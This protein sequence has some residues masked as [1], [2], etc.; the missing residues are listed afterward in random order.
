MFIFVETLRPLTTRR[1]L[2]K[3]Q[4]EREYFTIRLFSFY[5]PEQSVNLGVGNREY[6][7]LLALLAHQIPHLDA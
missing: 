4:V 6:L 1:F 2:I 7:N 5:L 3:T